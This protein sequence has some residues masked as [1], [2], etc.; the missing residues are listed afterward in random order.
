MK[1]WAEKKKKVLFKIEQKD[2]KLHLLFEFLFSNETACAFI[3][4][5]LEKVQRD[6]PVF[7]GYG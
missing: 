4:T 7:R 2:Q 1:I 5:Y 6:L 3:V